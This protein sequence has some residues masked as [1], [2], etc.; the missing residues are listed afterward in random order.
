MPRIE[1]ALVPVVI[2]L[3]RGLREL[4]V[5]FAIVGALVAELLLDARPRRVT[6]DADVA[7]LVASFA[8]FDALKGRLAAYGFAAHPGA[9]SPAA[10]GRQQ[11]RAS[12]HVA[13]AVAADGRL[14]A[15]GR[16]SKATVAGVRCV[17][18]GPISELR[19]RELDHT[20][21]GWRCHS[22]G[23]AGDSWHVQRGREQRSNGRRLCATWRSFLGRAKTDTS[24]GGTHDGEGVPFGSA[25]AF[26]LWRRRRPATVI[27][28]SAARAPSPASAR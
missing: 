17:V 14:G 9:A 16:W 7:V 4:G 3:E 18:A 21:A 8:D 13:D 2:D 1:P 28:I 11:S 5:P 26:L 12:F 6:T 23:A 10:P 15:R 20:S 25:C 27:S 19:W 22:A 24:R